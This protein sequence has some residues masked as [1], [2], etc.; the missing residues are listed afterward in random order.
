MIYKQRL[1]FQSVYKALLAPCLTLSL[2]R[3]NGD[4][5]TPVTVLV[6]GREME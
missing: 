4:H 6:H 1:H 3:T 5:V 2:L